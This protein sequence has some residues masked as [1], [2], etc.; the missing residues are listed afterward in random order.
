MSH[1]PPSSTSLPRDINCYL[2]HIPQ[3]EGWSAKLP[4]LTAW[5]ARVAALPEVAKVL[6]AEGA[7]AQH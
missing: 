1:G 6:A 4:H 7:L 2:L 3:V 5:K